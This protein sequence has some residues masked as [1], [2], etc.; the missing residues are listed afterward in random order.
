[1]FFGLIL[2]LI[3]VALLFRDLTDFKIHNWWAFFILIP[4]FGSFTRAWD[5]YQAGGSHLTRR[6]SSALLS[7]FFFVALTALLL[8]NLEW[9]LFLPI[10]LILFGISGLLNAF[11]K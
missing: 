1:M 6:A 9:E 10:I 4:A 11:L 2:I 5:H 3:G 8:F 7:G